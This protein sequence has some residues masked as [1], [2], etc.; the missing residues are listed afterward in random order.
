MAITLQAQVELVKDIFV[1]PSPSNP[2]NL[3]YFNNHVYFVASYDTAKNALYKS[4]GTETGTSLFVDFSMGSHSTFLYPYV[5]NNELYFYGN[6]TTT[7]GGLTKTDGTT[8]TTIANTNE[9][10]ID[11]VNAFIEYNGLL[12]FSANAS[13]S[14]SQQLFKTDGTTAGTV[15]V[16]SGLE[17]SSLSD[18]RYGRAVYNGKLYFTGKDSN[19]KELWVTDGTEAGTVMVKDIRSNGSSDP[20]NFQVANGLLFFNARNDSDGRELWVSDGTEAGTQMVKDI[21]VG[22]SSNPHEMITYNNQLYFVANSAGSGEE[23][24]TSD[25]TE[26]GTVMVKEI[27]S[28]S[29]GANPDELILFDNKIFFKARDD[30][31]GYEL[32][33]S[34]GT[35]AG[36]QIVKDIFLGN[37][38]DANPRRLTLFNGELY[39]TA[40]TTE[41]GYEL[42]KTNGTESGTV[43]LSDTWPDGGSLDP[44]RLAAGQQSLFFSGSDGVT[45]VEFYK[46]TDNATGSVDEEALSSIRLYHSNGQL[47]LTSPNQEIV[48]I[49]LYTIQGKQVK[50]FSKGQIL[51]DQMHITVSPGLYIARLTSKDGK[52]S[53]K[54]MLI[55]R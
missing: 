46:Y 22:N 20:H 23:L 39:F 24:W 27:R 55:H 32:W 13:F 8:I 51:Q 49:Q 29:S 21:Y 33:S 53:S 43:R 36:T 7:G 42:Y 26:A 14:E 2:I 40:T 25:G 31:R 44:N 12:Y 50:T 47:H 35:E 17:T 16:K 10:S 4:D 34:D 1:G 41:Y 9:N 38:A 15:Q 5:Y 52:Q 3:T 11:L 37:D 28:G 19:G 18:T 30:D 48:Q 54:K 45:G 6:S